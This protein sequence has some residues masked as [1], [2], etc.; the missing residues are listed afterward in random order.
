MSREQANMNGWTRRVPRLGVL[1]VF[2]ST[3][4]ACASVLA[5]TRLQAPKPASESLTL[6]ET[7]DFGALDLPSSP[8][9]SELDRLVGID[10]NG[11]F[12]GERCDELAAAI[13]GELRQNPA[14]LLASYLAALCA[15]PEQ[16]ILE[17]QQ[18]G[19]ELDLKMK[20]AELPAG[21]FFGDSVVAVS[22]FIDILAYLSWFDLDV[23]A[24]FYEVA[25]G[26]RR[27]YYVCIV[28]NPENGRQS[29]IRF[30]LTGVTLEI[31]KTLLDELPASSRETVDDFPAAVLVAA[32][33]AAPDADA[34]ALIGLA[35]YEASQPAG[36]WTTEEVRDLLSRAAAQGS[37]M[38]QLVLARALLL[39]DEPSAAAQVFT[40][41]TKASES[42]LALADVML[43]ALHE[44]GVGVTAS[45][46]EARKSL[47]S[48]QKSLGD[49]QAW[50]ELAR[51]YLT[52]GSRLQDRALGLQWLEKAARAGHANAQNDLGVEC[53]ADQPANPDQRCTRW[54][55]KAARQGV[56]LAM[57]N[58]A[59]NHESG[60]GL[61]R[62]VEQARKYYQQAIE[63]GLLSAASSLGYLMS[64]SKVDSSDDA[65]IAALYKT[66][67]EW[68]DPWGQNNYG[69][70]LRDGIGVDKDEA[71]AVP[72]FR[73]GAA[74]GNLSALLGLAGAYEWGQG[75][76]KDEESAVALYQFGASRNGNK[77]MLS[78]ALMV[79]DGRGTEKD[80]DR[81][82]KI[83]VLAAESGNSDA[84]WRLGDAAR[85]GSFLDTDSEVAE[86]WFRRSALDGNII[87]MQRLGNLLM[88]SSSIQDQVEG[89][90]WLRK[91]AE[92][93]DS[94]A[95]SDLGF[96]YQ[97]GRGVEVDLAQAKAWFRKGEAA[98]NVVAIFN[99][100]AAHQT[101]DSTEQ[102]LATARGYFERASSM[103]M[104]LAK[105][106]LGD[107]LVDGSGGSKDVERGWV[108]MTEAADAGLVQCQFRMGRV[109]RFGDPTLAAERKK[110]VH[111]LELASAQGSVEA[112][113]QLVEISM[114][115][116]EDDAEKIAEGF[117]TLTRLAETGDPHALFLLAEACLMGRPW[118]RD[119]ACARSNLERAGAAGSIPAAPNLGLFDA[120]GI[121]GPVDLDAAEQWFRVAIAEGATQSRY[122]LGRLLL[123]QG[124]NTQ[125]AVNLLVPGADEGNPGSV[126][127][128]LRYCRENPDCE[129]P[130]EKLAA[131]EK[132]LAGLT[133]RLKNILAWGLACDSLS[134]PEDGRY[135]VTLIES[136]PAKERSKWAV[137]DTLAA[138]H[139]RAGEFAIAVS[140]QKKSI[141]AL[142]ETEM[143]VQR[144]ILQERLARY[145]AGQTWDLPY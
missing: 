98:G 79:M 125:E 102:D 76:E 43:S 67:A 142:P 42:G 111:Y 30:D 14:S 112:A 139:A 77:A 73:R 97:N 62:N 13:D 118:P 120:A 11:A 100:G 71:R 27:L 91:A 83:L 65:R 105:C 143:R 10:L 9:V 53:Y 68:G 126:Y 121:A 129:V 82:R 107:M 85:D 138:A 51:V 55:E 81:G 136:L 63:R 12:A 123:H 4:F 61:E 26:G 90:S 19:T 133:P 40:L 3:V 45:S 37:S 114:H 54:Y 95:Y 35:R 93:G 52:E 109:F 29:N 2:T 110:A 116:N 50:Y 88:I 47:Q 74:Q 15:A 49:G 34:S 32:F 101:A 38:G 96:A 144:L 122:E 5:A 86:Q 8:G 131:L 127:V 115:D 132:Q 64:R 24:D 140:V 69:V 130:R 99:L 94:D 78:L 113:A 58:L 80:V 28:R 87:G 104:V 117:A 7:I 106:R 23:Y 41:A 145:E 1:A 59:A 22:S 89:I 16:S 108:L 17:Y 48:A 6:P 84:M 75:I 119:F 46:G 103:G 72:W 21:R 25:G 128:L 20:Q 137:L 60:S 141:D 134:D 135:A 56:A 33:A 18:A 31:Q 36:A 124:K 44:K 70:V 39:G 66:A 57:S 92:Q